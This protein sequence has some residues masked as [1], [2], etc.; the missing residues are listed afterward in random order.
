MSELES[1]LTNSGILK[2]DLVR[3]NLYSDWNRV[4]FPPIDD[5]SPLKITIHTQ[6]KQQTYSEIVDY[7]AQYS[8]VSVHFNLKVGENYDLTL[9]RSI[10]N[11]M[12]VSLDGYE[13]SDYGQLESIPEQILRFGLKIKDSKKLSLEFLKKFEKLRELSLERH[14]NDIE[15]LNNLINLETLKLR[16]ISKP[17]AAF[18]VENS[19]LKR[20]ELRL[21]GLS[22]IDTIGSCTN[23]EY[24][25]LWS[26][27]RLANVDA[28]SELNNLATLKLDQLSKVT[29]IKSLSNLERLR[30]L[31]LCKM[32]RLESLQWAADI[33]NLERLSVT[34]TTHL[35][36]EEF[37]VFS[38]HKKL[39]QTNIYI[40]KKN[41]K[42]VRDL[43]NLP[44]ITHFD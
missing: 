22:N 32:K 5:T 27:N 17:D 28:I 19:G 4:L 9:L 7:A 16:S 36:V 30:F 6:P 44:E 29:N 23:L 3:L 39:K 21:G 25:E 18:L 24:L 11:L 2:K 42:P 34:E 10:P 33:P 13:F 43:L 8:D 14:S 15:C 1:A 26:I 20:L 37:S 12:A 31:S 41:S 40:G 35:G 38:N